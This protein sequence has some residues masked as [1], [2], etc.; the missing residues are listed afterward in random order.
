ME[1]KRTPTRFPPGA[2]YWAITRLESG[3]AIA[4]TATAAM[5]MASLNLIDPPY[6][7]FA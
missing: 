6:S 4:V 2:G 5:T 3:E 1:S 7:A